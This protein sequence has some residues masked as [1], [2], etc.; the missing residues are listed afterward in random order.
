MVGWNAC[1][2]CML[3]HLFSTG[4]GQYA[5]SS[6][7]SVGREEAGSVRSEA[8]HVWFPKWG[9][10]MKGTTSICATA[11]ALAVG[12]RSEEMLLVE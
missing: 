5:G 9:N 2:I 4:Y 8:E 10:L 1:C 11:G 12:T 6:F 3:S 7:L